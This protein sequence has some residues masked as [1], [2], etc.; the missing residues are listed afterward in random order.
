VKPRL[1][2][3]VFLG[4]GRITS[5]LLAGLRLSGY[6]SPLVVH[7]RNPQKLRRLRRQYGVI[8]EPNLQRAVAQ[9]HL[10]IIAVRPDSVRAL[11]QNIAAIDR[12]L[13]A[14][15]LAAGIP[16]AN[17]RRWL[18]SPARW[19]RAM[20]SPVCRSG[21]GLTALAF[22]RKF[23]RSAR[24]TV[25]AL[26]AR[27][28]SV[29]ELPEKQFDVFTVTYSSSH[30]Y[31]A[32]AALAN[33]AQKLGLDR[34]TSLLAA[35]HGLAD[36]IAAWRKGNLPLDRLLHEAATPGGTAAATMDA[37]KTAGYHRAIQRGLE[38]GVARARKNSKA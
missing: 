15:S 28:G 13:N 17:L 30:G 3:V 24:R 22:D 6:K 33:S 32:L 1:N 25:E 26:F 21:D 23:S 7:D 35:A 36:G 12:P 34:K 18:P 10:L 19:A 11:L 2:A 38:A 37:M 5:A 14:V 20:P 29:L 8:A 31:H 4:G 9:A 27:V 16:L